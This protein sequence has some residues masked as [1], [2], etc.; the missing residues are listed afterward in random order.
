MS[1]LRNS[2]VN[3]LAGLLPAVTLLVTMPFIVRGLGDA[4]YGL[5][6]LI[7]AVMGYFAV[8]DINIAAGATK[9]VS[10][11]H[12]RGDQAS[13]SAVMNLAL[14]ISMAIGLLGAAMMWAG[15]DW[16]VDHA[17][18]VPAPQHDLGLR[19]LHLAAVGFLV[20]QVQQALQSLPQAVQRYSLSASCEAAFGVLVPVL[21]V[22]AL[23][24]G[25][26]L[27]EVLLVR[28]VLSALNMGVLLVMVR[29]LFPHWRWVWPDAMLRRT[30]LS[31]SG[32]TYLGRLASLTYFHAD[33]FIISAMLG[34]E[35]VSYYAIAS[36]IANRLLSL[37]FRFSSVIYPAASA[38]AVQGRWEELRQAYFKTSRYVFFINACAVALVCLFAREILFYWMGPRFADAGWVVVSVVALGMLVDS[39]SNLPSLVNDGM[40]HSRLTGLF[41]ISRAIFGVAVVVLGTYCFGLNGVAFGHLLASLVVVCAFLWAVHR[42]TIP[43]KLRDYVRNCY[44]LAFAVLAPAL[45]AAA[46]FHT[47]EV[48]T[49]TQMALASV[50]LTALMAVLA[51]RRVLAPEDRARVLSRLQRRGAQGPSA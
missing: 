46:E 25:G 9:Y 4:H 20:A 14:A 32:Y 13:E 18:Q 50:L 48:Y 5:L 41:A 10:E 11:F 43:F 30:V 1:L 26:G 23:S 40:G 27:Y 51:W 16:L 49:L 39:A 21:T 36:T 24:L 3:F 28:V 42:Y 34:L 38:L 19:Y 31:F 2:V 8:I 7:S 47:A 22:L 17:L 12:A 6:V 35:A 37:T 33:K 15:D 45:L 44:P 29:H